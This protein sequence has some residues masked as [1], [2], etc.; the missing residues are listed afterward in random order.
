MLDKRSGEVDKTKH[1][2][3]SEVILEWSEVDGVGVK[4]CQYPVELIGT[5]GGGWYESH[6]L[7]D[8]ANLLSL[9][10][11]LPEDVFA[12][13][14]HNMPGAH[15]AHLQNSALFRLMPSPL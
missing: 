12:A 15:V 5:G 3:V 1:S 9:V 13:S 4:V 11:H 10:E 6:L 14:K 7:G 2:E 8:Q